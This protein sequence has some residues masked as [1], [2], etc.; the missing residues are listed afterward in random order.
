[1]YVQGPRFFHQRKVEDSQWLWKKVWSLK[2]PTISWPCF[3]Y[4]LIVRTHS[5]S[6][7][8]AR[9]VASSLGQSSVR[10]SIPPLII[11][12][13]RIPDVDASSHAELFRFRGLFSNTCDYL[14]SFLL[15]ELHFLSH[16]RPIALSEFD[17]DERRGSRNLSWTRRTC[18]SKGSWVV[19]RL[20]WWY[21][22][23]WAGCHTHKTIL[24]PAW[25]FS[26]VKYCGE[27]PCFS[28][29]F[30]SCTSYYMKQI[31]ES[32]LVTGTIDLKGP[33][34]LLSGNVHS[35]PDGYKIPTIPNQHM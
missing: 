22:N 26:I 17:G 33:P 12:I 19:L 23:P 14:Q 27:L 35:F 31:D 7:P 13:F 8:H 10:H 15:A 16:H 2:L 9:K 32:G 29:S 20:S 6:P 34:L 5:I 25:W 18:T 30:V 21:P 28:F 1:M 24:T 11:G 3:P 4:D